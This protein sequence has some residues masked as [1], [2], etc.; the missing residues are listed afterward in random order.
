MTPVAEI[1]RI[2]WRYITLVCQGRIII[3]IV[4]TT[5]LEHKSS[6]FNSISYA[7]DCFNRHWLIKRRHHHDDQ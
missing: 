6:C 5:R 7:C 4:L 1:A 2:N 3:L